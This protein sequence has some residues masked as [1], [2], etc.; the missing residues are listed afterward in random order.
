VDVSK[1]YEQARLQ[2]A[3]RSAQL[4]LMDA[5]LPPDRPVSRH[6][7]R[8]TAF[9]LVVGFMLTAIAAL[10]LNGITSAIG[11]EKAMGR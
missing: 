3:G 4:Q 9:A 5:A 6:V 7:V 11:R 8:N 10:F 1:R 2:V